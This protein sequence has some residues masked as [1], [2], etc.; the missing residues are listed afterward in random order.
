MVPSILISSLKY[1]EHHRLNSCGLDFLL[2][3]S[4]NVG[5]GVGDARTAIA[6]IARRAGQ[7]MFSRHPFLIFSLLLIHNKTGKGSRTA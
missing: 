5:L 6:W 3:N 7:Q 1:R 2:K 4:L